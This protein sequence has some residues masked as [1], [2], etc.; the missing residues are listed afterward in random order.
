MRPSLLINKRWAVNESMT[1]SA[2]FR[3]SLTLIVWVVGVT[4]RS[5]YKDEICHQSWR[6]SS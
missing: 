6:Y 5:Y 2:N 4:I 1:F 3:L